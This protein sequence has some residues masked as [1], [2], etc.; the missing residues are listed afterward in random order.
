MA[1]SLFSFLGFLKNVTKFRW[2][3]CGEVRLF[4]VD[5]RPSFWVCFGNGFDVAAREGAND[6]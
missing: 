5:E 2:H 1:L 3:S 6:H 4:L